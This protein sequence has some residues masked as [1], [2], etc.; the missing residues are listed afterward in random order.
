MNYAKVVASSACVVSYITYTYTCI[1]NDAH[2][3]T[4]DAGLTAATGSDG[5]SA[6][7]VSTL[8]NLTIPSL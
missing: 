6:Q 2:P 3:L 4:S 7:P 1:D 8:P 5:L